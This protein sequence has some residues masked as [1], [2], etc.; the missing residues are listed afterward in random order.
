MI[1]WIETKII[2]TFLLLT[3]ILASP[4]IIYAMIAAEILYR[5]EK[6]EKASAK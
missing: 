3:V 5:K 6:K 4:F 1:N 2:Q